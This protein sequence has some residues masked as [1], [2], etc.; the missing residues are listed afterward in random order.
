MC[1]CSL[2]ATP[3]LSLSA[4]SPP[5]HPLPPTLSLTHQLH[6]RR[7]D[8]ARWRHKWLLALLWLRLLWRRKKN[9]SEDVSGTAVQSLKVSVL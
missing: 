3:S 2:S 9:T 5:P 8:Q 7:D 6:I 4:L 1:V